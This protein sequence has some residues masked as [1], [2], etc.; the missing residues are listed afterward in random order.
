LL[1]G[2]SKEDKLIDADK[3]V[4]KVLKLRMWDE[5]TKDKNCML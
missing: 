5:I 2:I 1:V 3:I 4:D